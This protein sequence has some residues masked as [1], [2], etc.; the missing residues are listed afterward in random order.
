METV[1]RGNDERER[2]KIVVGGNN[3]REGDNA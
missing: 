2:I 3:R 1:V